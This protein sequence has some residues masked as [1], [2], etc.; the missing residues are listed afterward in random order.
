MSLGISQVSPILPLYFHEMGL[1]DTGSV[2]RWSGASMGITFLIVCLAAPFWGRLADRKGR[3]I[4]LIRSSL[5]MAICSILLGF[6]STPEG[7]FLVRTLQGLVSGFYSASVTLI[8]SETPQNHTSW[9]LGII[10][11]FNLAGSLAGPLV[12][13]YLSDVVGIR[14]DFFIIGVLMLIS[15]GLTTMLVHENYTKPLVEKQTFR[16]LKAHL[17]EFSS[18]VALSATSFLY[19]I[20]VT[21]ISPIMT[22]YIKEI[23]PSNAENIAFISGAVFSAMGIAQFFSGS[24]LGKLVD[25]IGPRK[26]LIYSMLYVGILNIPQ[27]YVD[28]V[29]VLGF[30]RF[31]QGFG[32]GGMLP[33]LNTYLAS[34]TPKEYTGQVFSYNQSCLFMGY[35][36][37]SFGGSIVAAQFSFTT[38]FWAC[39]LTF[40]GAALWVAYKLK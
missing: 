29:Y 15:F 36:L 7:V 4:T 40:I 20:S 3:K 9:A 2:A 16:N 8:A 6:Q 23:L 31:L 1:S 30:I 13:G 27:A 25:R 37:G 17:P 14:N 38:L 24:P 22:V 34:K 32:L 11:S 19:A 12:G 5:G 18:L 10:A 33:A 35:F 28:S 39:S 26:V 21:A